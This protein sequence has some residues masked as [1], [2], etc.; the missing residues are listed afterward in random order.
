MF[1]PLL[2][3]IQLRKH[4]GSKIVLTGDHAVLV[5]PARLYPLTAEHMP[6]YVTFICQQ[7][8]QIAELLIHWESIRKRL[9]GWFFCF[10]KRK[11]IYSK[12]VGRN[13]CDTFMLI[14]FKLPMSVTAVEWAVPPLH[15]GEVRCSHNVI[16]RKLWIL[17]FV[18]LIY[19]ISSN[20][21][22][23]FIEYYYTTSFGM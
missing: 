18:S 16:I 14:P 21:N 17:L 8:T 11:W 12:A 1:Y 6:S 3:V 22:S 23:S 2:S 13:K 9:S 4:R 19:T 15:M 5:S 20:H 7:A 10:G